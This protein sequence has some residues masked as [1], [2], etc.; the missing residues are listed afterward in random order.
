MVTGLCHLHYLTVSWRPSCTP[1]QANLRV[2]FCQERIEAG[3]N[4]HL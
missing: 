1:K 3:N 4:S 2:L